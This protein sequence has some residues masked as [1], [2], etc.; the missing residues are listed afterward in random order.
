MT[1]LATAPA[2]VWDVVWPVLETDGAFGEAVFL[3]VAHDR[4]R[5]RPALTER[6]LVD[7]WQ[8]LHT[9]FPPDQDPVVHGG[10]IVTPRESVANLRDRLLPELAQRGDDA[11][12]SRRRLVEDNPQLP[13]LA[14]LAADA[15]QAARRGDWTPLPTRQVVALLAAPERLLLRTS[16]DLL[17][18][19]LDAMQ[20]IQQELGQGAPPEA[21][22]LWNHGPARRGGP[23]NGC[24]PKSED[25]IS[26]YLAGHLRR[27]LQHA[28]VNREVQ[29]EVAGLPRASVNEST[30]S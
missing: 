9:R 18:A 8:L 11:A 13:W 15:E 7:L 29:T 23:G 19:V 6:Q 21:T 2:V 25:E 30:S 12:A 27:H 1:A 14:R 28:A 24:R 17:D 20:A 4:D 22:L 10:H 3:R 5:S 26:D 16:R